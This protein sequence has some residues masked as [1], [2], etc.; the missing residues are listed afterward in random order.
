[1]SAERTL[2]DFDNIILS[3][4]MVFGQDA[5]RGVGT[6]LVCIVV[7]FCGLIFDAE[8]RFIEQK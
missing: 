8:G 1:M 2:L 4:A 7:V 6:L 5:L 3:R